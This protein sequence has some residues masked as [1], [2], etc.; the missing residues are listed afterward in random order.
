MYWLPLI[1]LT[2]GPRSEEAAAL[3]KAT[4]VVRDSIHCLRF[5][6]RPDAG[7]KT[8]S[9]ERLVPI[10]DVLIR[11]GFIDWWREQLALPGLLH[12]PELPA[13]HDGK[14][15]DVFG[16]RRSRIFTRLRLTD[17][18][19]DFYAGRMTVST[20]LLALGA[21]HVRQ[22]IIGHEHAGALSQTTVRPCRR[23]LARSGRPPVYR[24][25]RAARRHADVLRRRGSR[26]GLSE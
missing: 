13:G 26:S 21:D 12:F 24:G 1:Q 25:N 17:P 16:K 5:E 23:A 4:I 6:E 14:I 7:Q 18:R 10:P 19:E 3:P 22:W 20:Q 2:M 15:S 11:V 8:L 9:S